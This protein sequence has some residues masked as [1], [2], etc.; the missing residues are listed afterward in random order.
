M[1]VELPAVLKAPRPRQ[2]N[3]HE[4]KEELRTPDGPWLT[5]G[6]GDRL[7]KKRSAEQSCSWEKVTRAY[8]RHMNETATQSQKLRIRY[9]GLQRRG[10]FLCPSICQERDTPAAES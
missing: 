6:A 5:D 1:R 2:A 8:R 3:D 4:T 10:A 9:C 7:T